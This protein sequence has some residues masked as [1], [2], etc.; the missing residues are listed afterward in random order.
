MQ[1]TQVRSLGREDPLEEDMAAHPSL[2]A[3]RIPWTEEPGGY[4]PWGHSQTRLRDWACVQ[5]LTG[6]KRKSQRFLHFSLII[7]PMGASPR[8]PKAKRCKRFWEE[9]M[10][11][12]GLANGFA[13]RSRSL[14]RA[15]LGRWHPSD[16]GELGDQLH[17]PKSQYPDR[18]EPG[19]SLQRGGPE[20]PD[21]RSHGQRH[22][23]W[24]TR[25][26]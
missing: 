8:I 26:P 4:K 20:A 22:S 11:M 16:H 1:E 6:L 21:F 3:W 25:A 19:R 17:L 13:L 23:R 12:R 5:G 18:H 14:S 7:T 10:R 24:E 9:S 15:A 2:L